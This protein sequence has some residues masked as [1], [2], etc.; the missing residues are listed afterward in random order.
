MTSELK[1]KWLHLYDVARKIGVMQPWEDFSESDRFTYIWKDK[2]KTV[3]FTFIG[4]SAQKYGI[5]CYVGEE[6][7]IRARV[8]LTGKNDKCE[9]IF[10]LQNALICLWD[11][12]E[13]L[14]KESYALIKELGFKPRGKGAWLHFDR[15]EVG[16]A[17][18]TI[19]EKEIDLLTIAFENLHMM[20]RA[21][22]EQGLDPEFDKGKNLVRW[23]EPKDKL[24]Y[25]HPFE[26]EIPEGIITHP[27]VTVHENDWM[28]EVRSMKS[29]DYSVELDW[30]YVGVIYDDEDG[31]GT[32]PRMLL[33]VEP[34]NGFILV[35]EM[36]SP[37]H[38]QP[39]IVFNVLDHFVKRYG[40]PSE[41]AIC[42]EDL[43]GIL[44]DVC[45]KVGIKL[46][47]KKRLSAVN[48]ARKT[49]LAQIV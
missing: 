47:V 34:K 4:E 16:F 30:S 21:I 19:D 42:D 31:R 38:N 29:A 41:I 26:I 49:I 5:A 12:R 32:F 8:R 15:Y 3:F 27:Q 28:R 18:T 25:T 17:P 36:L 9:P 7:Y 14:S 40:K 33:A 10:A 43:K 48:N 1:E 39:G 22:Y 35:N 23:Y 44:T 24:F 13:D 46:T 2:S 11:D 37:S 20:L 45:K 6:D